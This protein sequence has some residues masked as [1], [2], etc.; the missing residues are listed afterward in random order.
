MMKEEPWPEEKEEGGDVHWS[1]EEFYYPNFDGF[2]I[3]QPF[4]LFGNHEMKGKTM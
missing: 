4:A 2:I 1:L 3:F